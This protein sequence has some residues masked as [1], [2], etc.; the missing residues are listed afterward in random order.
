MAE[1]DNEVAGDV[2]PEAED[3]KIISTVST[4]LPTR[5]TEV[6]PVLN[7]TPWD[8]MVGRTTVMS[9][10][11]RTHG[12]SGGHERGGRNGGG[13]GNVRFQDNVNDERTISSTEI[14]EYNADDAQHRQSDNTLN[15]RGG[16]NG[17]GFGRGAYG[18]QGGRS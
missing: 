15:D 3:S 8:P 11:D 2:I 1:A 16:R 9:M 12:G 10:Q 5:S 14:V 6:S 17:R 13:R 18:R 4:T 7:G